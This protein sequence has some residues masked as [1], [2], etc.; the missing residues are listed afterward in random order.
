MKNHYHKIESLRTYIDAQRNVFTRA[1]LQ[2]DNCAEVSLGI[3]AL[4]AKSGCP[5]TDGDFVK[6]CILLVSKSVPQC[7]KKI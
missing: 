3:T 7:H 2:L 4:I 5:F 6:E 1:P